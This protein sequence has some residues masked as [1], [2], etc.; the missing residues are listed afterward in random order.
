MKEGKSRVADARELSLIKKKVHKLINRDA[1]LEIA[2]D[3][4]NIPSPTGFEKACAD[5]I[6]ERYRAA[7]I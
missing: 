6:I 3:L 5:Y 7:G 1:L 2:C 4:V